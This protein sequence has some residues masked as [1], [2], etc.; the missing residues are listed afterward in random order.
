MSIA[1]YLPPICSED[2]G[3][4]LLDGGYVNNLPGRFE[5][6]CFMFCVKRLH[7]KYSWIIADVMRNMGVATILAVDIGAK[8]KED[9]TNYG[10]SLSGWWLLWKKYYPFTESVNVSLVI[11]ITKLFIDMF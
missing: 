11:S 9:L 2:D 6:K 10:D 5:N 4:L 8:E 7:V 1:G 3:H